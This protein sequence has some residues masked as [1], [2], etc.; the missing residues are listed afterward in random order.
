MRGYPI[1]GAAQR[2]RISS[3][4]AGIAFG[5][6]CLV[7]VMVFVMQNL[8]IVEVRYLGL[9]GE[10]PL[11]VLAILS[12]ALGAAIVFAFGTARI[13]QLRVRSRRA[14]R[15]LDQSSARHAAVTPAVVTSVPSSSSTQEE[16]MTDEY[17]R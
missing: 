10:L 2:T 3:A 16:V 13:A 4:W 14:S 1:K 12:G 8:R 5:L 11:G 9:H 17:R 15:R 6:F 7:I